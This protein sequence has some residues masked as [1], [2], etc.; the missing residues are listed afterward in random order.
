MFNRSLVVV[1][2]D[3]SPE[4]E[5]TVQYAVSIAKRRGADVHLIQVVSRRSGTLWRAP[6]SERKLRARLRALRPAVEQ[7]GVSV[8][9]VT[10]RGRH[11]S[12]IPAYAQLNGASLVVLGHHYGSWR[13]WRNSRVASRLSRSSPVPVLVVPVLGGAAP[14]SVSRILAAVD[15]TVSSA[16]ALRTAADWSKRHGARLIMLHAMRQPLDQMALSGGEAWRRVQRVPAEVRGLSKRLK[17]KAAILGSADAAAVVVTGNAFRGLVATAKDTHADLIVMGV[18][19]R[20][21][22]DEVLFGSN[23]RAVL[24]WATVPVLVVPVVGGA[25]EWIDEVQH[26]MIQAPATGAE[27]TRQAA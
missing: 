3:G 17:R 27:L 19:P 18:A 1:P 20:S 10:L 24:S 25:H 15:F 2:V 14:P 22:V 8:R 21:R 23:L 12:V 4:T 26:E 5:P 16:I 6:E 9:I 13:L 11:D 7:A